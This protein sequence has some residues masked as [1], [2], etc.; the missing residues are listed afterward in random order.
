[1][2]AFKL[3][4][5][6]LLNLFFHV[7]S[8]KP[9]HLK[10]PIRLFLYSCPWIT[11]GFS[12]WEFCVTSKGSFGLIFL[13]PRNVAFQTKKQKPSPST[14]KKMNLEPSPVSCFSIA[15]ILSRLVSVTC[16]HSLASDLFMQLSFNSLTLPLDTVLLLALLLPSDL[17]EQLGVELAG[18]KR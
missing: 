18:A 5:T 11:S 12:Y 17:A 1:M 10:N 9:L 13:P 14:Q 3:I 2:N 7:S 6:V 16:L 4:Q 15:L 8:P